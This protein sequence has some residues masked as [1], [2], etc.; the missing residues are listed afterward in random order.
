MK[1][2]LKRALNILPIWAGVVWIDWVFSLINEGTSSDGLLY[3][4]GIVVITLVINYVIFGAIT[5]WHKF[6]K[7]T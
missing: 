7:E 6:E 4:V 3:G 2:I 1:N 5:L